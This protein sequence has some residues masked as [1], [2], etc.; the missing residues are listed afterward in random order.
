MFAAQYPSVQTQEVSGGAEAPSRTVQ[1]T[2]VRS[3]SVGRAQPPRLSLCVSPF[4]VE[5]HRGD[6]QRAPR[7]RHLE[8]KPGTAAAIVPQVPPRV[9]QQNVSVRPGGRVVHLRPDGGCCSTQESS[10]STQAVASPLLHDGGGGG[11][12]VSPVC[13]GV[14]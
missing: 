2:G 4:W 12:R 7:R 5:Q 3:E 1:N 9:Q 11:G 8:V 10:V 13:A 14:L 6:V